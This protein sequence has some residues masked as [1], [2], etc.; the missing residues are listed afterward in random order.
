MLSTDPMYLV[1]QYQTRLEGAA[2]FLTKE[3]ALTA[4]DI[5][6]MQTRYT[7]TRAFHT[8]RQRQRT[9]WHN[10][11]A[12]AVRMVRELPD[13]LREI[14]EGRRIG[15]PT[16]TRSDQQHQLAAYLSRKPVEWRD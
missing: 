16:L 7:G 3:S 10:R 1:H 9:Y 6:N 11:R 14:A 2:K 12:E 4:S 15:I 8:A 13:N 5:Q